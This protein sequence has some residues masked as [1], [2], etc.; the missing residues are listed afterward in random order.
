MTAKRSILALN[1][2]GLLLAAFFILASDA[3]AQSKKDAKKAKALADKAAAAFVKRDY[4]IAV[5]GYG[6]AITL[7]SNNPDYHF[8]KG[9][10]HHYLNENALALP[11]LNVALE[12]GY[13]KP[14]EIYRIRWRV[15]YAN[16]ELD[17]ALADIKQGLI[18]D[19][20]NLEF[21]QGLGD[22]SYSRNNYRE[23]VDAYQKVVLKDPGNAELY[24]N[25]ARAQE[26]L[27]DVD[28]QIAA[29]AE[30]I[31]RGTQSLAEA[32]R[33]MADGYRKQK[34]FDDAIASYQKIILAKP[35]TYSAYQSIA[36]IYRDQNKFNEAIDISRKA[37]KVFP[38]DGRIYTDLGLFYSLAGRNDEAIQAAQAGIRFLP[39]EYM[40]Y[41]NLCRAYNDA[42][43]PEMAIRE[44]NNALKRK[45]TDGET[46]F[47]L[48][49]AYDLTGKQ[50]EAT[51]FYKQAVTG[52]ME[53]TK[54]NPTQPDSFY[55]LGNAYR[56]DN[57]FE[58]AIAAY[59]KC[60][61]LSPKFGRARYNLAIIQLLQKNKTAALEQ[62]NLLREFDPEL[63][64]KLKAEIDRS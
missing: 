17:P 54:A 64:G 18:L 4:R 63:A 43:K 60:L 29:A 49:R 34:K 31:K 28:G 55:L 52:L 2:C 1:I 12:K 9:V 20:N 45:P 7:D 46:F 27:G 38:N 48:A 37:L 36:E 24:M 30:A 62:Y 19:P 41:T 5:D 53:E 51:K 10:G 35:D 16:K 6:Q 57:Q 15:H 59:S 22:I 56:A 3:S 44:C 40:A 32:H 25:I 14:L 50:S 33:I 39:D 21:L 42:K 26:S 8:W 47:Y 61:E 11:E 13:K 58:K 23:A